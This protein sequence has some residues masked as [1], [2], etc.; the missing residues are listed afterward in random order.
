MGLLVLGLA[1]FLGGHLVPAVPPLRRALAAPLGE[2]RYKGLFA[3]VSFAGIALIVLGYWMSGPRPPFFDPVPAA[4]ALAPYAMVLSFILF[5]AAN[6]RTHLRKTL[7]HP[8]LIGLFI[9]ALVH[10]L[11][12]GDG[13][14][15]VLFGAFVAYAVVDFISASARG[16]VKEFVPVAR[17][18]MMAV[19]GGIIVALVFML[20]HR[21]FFG[22]P[23]VPFSL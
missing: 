11:A 21:I 16:A 20:F 10:L 6:M 4:R 14:G 18:D 9:W 23:V 8:M 15:T 1:L 13:R 19:A 3:L 2:Q 22:Y 17:Q 12:S 7:R 5:A